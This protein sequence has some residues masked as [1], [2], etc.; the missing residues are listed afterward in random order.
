MSRGLCVCLPPLTVS[1][2]GFAEAILTQGMARALAEEV[3]LDERYV[4]EHLRD[5][6]AGQSVIAGGGQGLC[7][8]VCVPC[9]VRIL[10]YIARAPHFSSFPSYSPH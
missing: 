5:A 3:H 4:A 6:M 2:H 8:I 1:I 7:M 10:I 9:C